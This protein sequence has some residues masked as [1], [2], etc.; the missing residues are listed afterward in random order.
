MKI[1]TIGYTQKSA[2]EFF[3]L[4]EGHGIEQILDVRLKNTSQ[5]AGFTKKQDLEYFL[6]RLSGIGYD[7]LEFL[8]PTPEI[9]TAYEE[10]G[11]DWEVYVEEFL[12]LLEERKVL[13]SLERDLF[14]QKKCCLLCSE[15][16]PDLCHRRLVAEYLQES[17]TDVEIVHL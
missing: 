1:Y 5:L 3:S 16:A 17:W 8:A 4:L 2:E 12:K 13:E 14:S 15:P 9:R 11:N 6:R 10:S 7:H